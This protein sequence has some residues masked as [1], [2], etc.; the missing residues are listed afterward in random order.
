MLQYSLGGEFIKEWPNA[1]AA[2][3]G[4]GMRINGD[5]GL[6]CKGKKKSAG[7][8]IWKYKEDVKE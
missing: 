6:V 2:S 8:F 4:L 5:I 7:G 3:H 1:H